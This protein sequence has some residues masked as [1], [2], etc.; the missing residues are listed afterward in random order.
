VESFR[1]HLLLAG[2]AL[3]DPNFRRSVVLIAHH[4][5][6]GAVGVVLNDPA[7]VSVSEAIPQ[8]SSLVEPDEPLFV[9]GP[10]EPQAAVVVADFED[11]S[12]AGIVAFGTIGFLPPET[13]PQAEMG[14]RRARVFAGYS[15]WGPGQLEAEM[16]QESWIVERATPEDVFLCG[17]CS[18]AAV[19]RKDYVGDV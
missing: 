9:G 2:A 15:G 8:L 5:E 14:I 19:C 10:V 11:P 1:G 16:A 7:D 3:L 18:Y 13:G 17:F 12:L 4:D 6:E